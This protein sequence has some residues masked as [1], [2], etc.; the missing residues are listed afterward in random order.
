M[1]VAIQDVALARATSG[2]VCLKIRG[3][4]CHEVSEDGTRLFVR[5][6]DRSRDTIEDRLGLV[7]ARMAEVHLTRQTR[8]GLQQDLDDTVT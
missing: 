5:C 4:G 3:L 6:H 8:D 7:I 2:R 1:E